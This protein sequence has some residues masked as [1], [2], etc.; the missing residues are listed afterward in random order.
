MAEYQRIDR[1]PRTALIRGADHEAI[2]RALLGKAETTALEGA[3]RGVIEVFSIADGE[4]VLRRCRRGGLMG[5]LLSEG[6]ILCNRPEA[7]FHIHEFLFDNGVS[8]PEP[9]GV[10]WEHR[11]LMYRGAMATRRLH[12]VSVREWLQSGNKYDDATM[13]SIGELIRSM[14]DLGVYHADLHVENILLEDSTPYLIDFDNARRYDALSGV[15]RARNLLRLRRSFQKHGLPNSAYDA[16]IAG[17]GAITFP[18]WLDRAYR[19]KG[20]AS[21]LL[22]AS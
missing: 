5:R 21:D 17:Y 4:G 15:Q 19:I 12:A 20:K 1:P 22:A 8:V 3:G 6:Y 14:H 10:M 7:E 16:I 13:K 2:G 11:G 9:L 18:G